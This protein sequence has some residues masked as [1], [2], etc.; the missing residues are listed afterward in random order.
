MPKILVVDDEERIRTVFEKFLTKMGFEVIQTSAGEE[1]IRLLKSDEK[2]D[3]LI[4]DLKIPKV[5]GLEVLKEK[6]YLNDMRPVIILTGSIDAERHDAGLK[7]L[8]FGPGDII[9][10]PADLFL[11]LD[12]LKKKLNINN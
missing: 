9:Y 6:H 2:I 5:S 7:E 11:L 12:M 3:L 8:G 4:I 10:K 1:A